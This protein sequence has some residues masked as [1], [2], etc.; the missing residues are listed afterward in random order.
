[1][2]FAFITSSV[3]LLSGQPSFAQSGETFAPGSVL[4]LDS[5]GKLV[6]TDAEVLATSDVVGVALGESNA[7]NQWIAY[8][9]K[10]C[11][12]TVSG[13]TG[14]ESYYVGGSADAGKV[15]VRAD[16]VTGTHFA[17]IAGIAHSATVFEVLGI[18][19]GFQ[20]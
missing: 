13:L 8:A 5:T 6:K 17:S 2:A 4:R 16:A 15:G 1:M 9:G 19:T 10:G 11:K 7:A 20:L 14:G 3:V 18:K 12:L